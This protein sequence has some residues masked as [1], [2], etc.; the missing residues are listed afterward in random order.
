MSS[1][2]SEKTH[3]DRGYFDED[4]LSSASS[5]S[6]QSV[7]ILD[8]EIEVIASDEPI[9]SPSRKR[10]SKGKKPFIPSVKI[11]KKWSSDYQEWVKAGEEEAPSSSSSLSSVNPLFKDVPYACKFGGKKTS[12]SNV[13]D[14][15]KPHNLRICEAAR[16][17]SL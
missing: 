15:V 10:P 4:V 17:P 12:R 3:S 11:L 16:M 5:S 8:E 9:G 13:L 2:D 14:K 6:S 7:E 1:S